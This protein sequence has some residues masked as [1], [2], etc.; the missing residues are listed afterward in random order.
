M[1]MHER[2]NPCLQFSLLA[3]Q[4]YVGRP[5]SPVTMQIT[6]MPLGL[7]SSQALLVSDDA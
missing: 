2:T 6:L 7:V 4:A 5:L 3:V 1:C